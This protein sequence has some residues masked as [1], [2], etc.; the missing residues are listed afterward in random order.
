MDMVHQRTANVSLHITVYILPVVQYQQVGH[1]GH[2]T[3]T[4]ARYELQPC[5]HHANVLSLP[6]ISHPDTNGESCL[7]IESSVASMFG[8]LR[9]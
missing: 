7:E 3:K 9:V 1:T 5:F 8:N 6:L 4:S 2:G